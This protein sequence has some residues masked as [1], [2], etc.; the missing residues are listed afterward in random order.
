MWGFNDKFWHK[1]AVET[2]MLRKILLRCHYWQSINEIDFT[3]IH[4][5]TQSALTIVGKYCNNLKVIDL[6]NFR[7]SQSGLK[8]ITANCQNIT[9]FSMR[10][11]TGPCEKDLTVFFSKI[12]SLKYLKIVEGTHIKGKALASL[13]CDALEEINFTD[14]I[15]LKSNYVDEVKSYNEF[16]SFLLSFSYFFR[17]YRYWIIT[18][19]TDDWKMQK[20]THGYSGLLLVHRRQHVFRDRCNPN[21]Y[22]SQDHEILTIRIVRCHATNLRTCQFR[23]LDYT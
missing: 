8:S 10:S 18:S 9:R 5:L 7:L 19:L 14:V 21:D 16:I 2:P 12:K 20:V 3:Q 22:N 13:N 4:V 15:S 1:R 17:H 23:E 6:L 11:L